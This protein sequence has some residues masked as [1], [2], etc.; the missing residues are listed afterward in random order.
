MAAHKLIQAVK[1][2][3]SPEEAYGCLRELPNPLKEDD[4]EYKVFKKLDL[5]NSD[6]MD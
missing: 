3:C 1:S 5:N 2:K 4:G 6:Y